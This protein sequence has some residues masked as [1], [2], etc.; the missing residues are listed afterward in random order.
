M[1]VNEITG[2]FEHEF[3]PVLNKFRIIKVLKGH[4]FDYDF[5]K[6]AKDDDNII[7][8]PGVYV[9]YGNQTVYRVGRSL[10]NSRKRALEHI[11]ENTSNEDNE[12]FELGNYDDSELIL[13]NVV[14]INDSHWVAA[15]EI[16][17]ERVL[18][19][20]IKSGRAG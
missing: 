11:I 7:W 15:V 14:D 6:N 20:L 5:I 16:Y 4:K 13:I 3:A 18:N 8:H 17:L 2:V 1:N 10:D 12:I 9:F 19:P